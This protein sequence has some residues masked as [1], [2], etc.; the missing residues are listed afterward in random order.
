M[1]ENV[2]EIISTFEFSYFFQWTCKLCLSKIHFS[3]S[4]IAQHL[5]VHAWSIQEYE[6]EYGTPEHISGVTVLSN[7][8]PQPP[9]TGAA[10]A[11]S[12]GLGQGH[13]PPAVNAQPQA[14][15]GL[16]RP[17]SGVTVLSNVLPQ[18][19]PIGAAVAHSDGREEGH[20]PLDVDAQPQAPL[21]LIRP[22]GFISSHGIKLTLQSTSSTQADQSKYIARKS[23]PK[24]D[25]RKSLLSLPAYNYQP[26]WKES[27]PKEGR[28]NCYVMGCLCIF[29][30]MQE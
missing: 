28:I 2:F 25:F 3:R 23:V 18:H 26:P 21:G 8:L 13:V 15:L 22:T 6:D 9:P 10:V 1:R 17:R 12:D 30:Q 16:I 11:H 27:L 20:V 4:R 19:P 29:F 14:P 5:L 7:V 24:P